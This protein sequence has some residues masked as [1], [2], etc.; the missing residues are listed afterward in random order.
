[1]HFRSKSLI[2]ALALLGISHIAQ[3]ASAIA[4]APHNQGGYEAYYRTNEP[5]IATAEQNALKACNAAAKDDGH[6]GKCAVLPGKDGPN[7]WAIF[8]ADTGAFGF[9]HGSD[10]QTAVDRGYQECSKQ[11]KCSTKPSG[12]WFDRGQ[13]EGQTKNIS[14]D[15]KTA[16]QAN[17]DAKEKPACPPVPEGY[18]DASDR[19][20]VAEMLQALSKA[21]NESERI[22][23]AKAELKTAPQRMMLVRAMGNDKLTADPD[24]KK[25]VNTLS[26]YAINSGGL[27]AESMAAAVV[28]HLNAKSNWCLG[29]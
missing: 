21:R 9:G 5:D 17:V 26:A 7:H 29:K 4:Y 10:L 3:A 6:T 1:M 19:K 22:V 14:Q 27:T 2:M 16:K 15:K 24:F 11:G 28:D 23:I 25:A 18:W 12:T 13:G 8:F 20:F